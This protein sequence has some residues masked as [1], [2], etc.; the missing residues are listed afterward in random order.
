MTMRWL[1][2]MRLSMKLALTFLLLGLIVAG[3]GYFSVKQFDRLGG[4]VNT[5]FV[6]ELEPMRKLADIRFTYMN[7]YRRLHF[8]ILADD[9]VLRASLPELSAQDEARIGDLLSRLRQVLM[10]EDEQAMIARSEHVMRRYREVA[11][12]AMAAA[13]ADRQD[14]AVQILMIDVHPLALAVQT[15]LHDLLE[16]HTKDA[17]RL[18]QE[19][20][21]DI[22]AGRQLIV[23]MIGGGFVLALLLGWLVTRSVIRQ[24]GGEPAAAARILQRVG[25]GDMTVAFPLAPDDRSSMLYSMQQMV[26]R[27]VAVIADV[28]NVTGALV[29]ASEQVSTSAQT[30]SSNAS[31]Q[32]VSVEETSTSVEQVS[33]TVAQ[34]AAHARLADQMAA[35]NTRDVEEG[36]RVVAE[37]VAAM[38]QIIRKIGIIDDIA[39]QTN[40]LALNATIEA[41]RAGEHGR[42]FA[43]VAA[44]VRKLAE[45][46]QAAAQEITDVAEGSSALSARAGVL[47]AQMVPAISKTADLVQEI[48][49]ASQEQAAGL[50]QINSAVSQLAQTTHVNASASEEFSATAEELSTQAMQL[51]DMVRYFKVETSLLDAPALAPDEAP[52]SAPASYSGPAFPVAVPIQ[53]DDL[54]D[55]PPDESRFV[56]F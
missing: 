45:R 21:Q 48:A 53:R 12:D 9:R 13:V 26:Q 50:E 8:A 14:A 43:V 1:T 25:R 5:I 51:Q 15:A 36:G 41:A 23:S 27:L 44:E 34:N 24:V 3:V 32:A 54:E 22:E 37:T 40:L 11:A 6:E 38:Q 28:R 31:D 4:R 47:L 7:H 16:L 42:G 19:S 30:L 10:N 20:T 46:S 39:Y 29:A 35:H 18:K 33:A 52:P 17:A 49:T 55:S 56:R 2:D